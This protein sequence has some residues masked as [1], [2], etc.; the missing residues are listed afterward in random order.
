ML[1]KIREL[2]PDLILHLGDYVSDA[3]IL[4]ESFPDLPLKMVRG[5]CDFSSKAPLLEEFE[6]ESHRIIM[7]HGHRYDV[8]SGLTALCDM[9]HFANAALLLF[10]HTH[11]PYYEQIGN[12]HV[13]NPGSAGQQKS[14]AFIELAEG[15]IRCAHVS[16]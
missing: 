15:H 12:M 13:L 8:K 9:G 10:G 1:I 16:L 11:V 5:N 4:S 2:K 3:R 7:T 6:L 14:A